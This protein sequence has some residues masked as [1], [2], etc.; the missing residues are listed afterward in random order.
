MNFVDD[1][2]PGPAADE[3]HDLVGKGRI[4]ES[5]GRDHDDIHLVCIEEG[6]KLADRVVGRRVDGEGPQPQSFR[7][8]NL[9]SHE[10]EQRRDEQGWPKP[11]FPQEVSGDEVDG[12]LAPASSLDQN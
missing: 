12:T 11:L 1:G 4:C 8:I 5:L 9:V 2:E 3:R 6:H 7:S 10:R